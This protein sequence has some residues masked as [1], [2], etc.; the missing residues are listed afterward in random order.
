MRIGLSPGTLLEAAVSIAVAILMAVAG[1]EMLYGNSPSM[2]DVAVP[3]STRGVAAPAQPAPSFGA[4]VAMP[5]V[6]EIRV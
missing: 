6:D 5:H 1:Y 2:H 3:A 4:K